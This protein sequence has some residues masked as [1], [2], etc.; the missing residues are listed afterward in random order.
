[1]VQ[2]AEVGHHD[3]ISRGWRPPLA[4][5]AALIALFLALDVVYPRIT[6]RRADRDQAALYEDLRT[7]YAGTT[8]QDVDG[9]F[10]ESFSP[11]DGGRFDDFFARR[12]G[13]RPS[14]LRAVDGGRGYEARYEQVRSG[15]R[16]CVVATWRTGSL[17]LDRRG[18]PACD[19]APDDGG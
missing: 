1:M 4:A 9:L 10:V 3:P 5:L 8:S 16:R 15:Q 14:S 18:G 7:A 2:A 17:D 19:V 13:H 12:S 6:G 11:G